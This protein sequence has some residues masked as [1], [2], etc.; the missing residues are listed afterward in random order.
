LLILVTSLALGTPAPV[1]A[2]SGDFTLAYQDSSTA[3]PAVAYLVRGG[4]TSCDPTL[5]CNGGLVEP[6]VVTHAGYYPND[7]YGYG[8]GQFNI[9]TGEPDSGFRG[10]ITL[11]FSHLPS[12]VSSQTATST[13][14]TD[15]TILYY[16]WGYPVYGTSTTFQLHADATAALG[17][18]A[19]TLTANNGLIT[20]SVTLTIQ[21]VNQ[22]PSLAL[23]NTLIDSQT[24]ISGGQ[25]FQLTVKLNYPVP[26]GQSYTIALTSDH[27]SIAPVPATVTIPAGAQSMTITITT[28]KPKQITLVNFTATYNGQT[29][30]GSIQVNPF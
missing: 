4:L 15:S 9:S 23:Y 21:V 16:D 17:S 28:Y 5:N 30:P 2:A 13:T 19:I 6:K 20:H 12:G 24:T 25:S 22:L 11:T 7:S 27:P 26:A 18:T 14:I 8:P 29:V 1:R 10:P 3:T